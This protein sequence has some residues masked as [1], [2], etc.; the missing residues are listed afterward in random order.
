MYLNLLI[1]WI[2]Q[3]LLITLQWN[4]HGLNPE[5]KSYPI[6]IVSLT[7]N[8]EGEKLLLWLKNIRNSTLWSYYEQSRAV[9]VE[10]R[11]GNRALKFHVILFIT[12]FIT[13]NHPLNDRHIPHCGTD[14]VI[15]HPCCSDLALKTLE[16]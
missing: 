11:S 10:T 4:L 2:S 12:P 5:D 1:I 15:I 8:E 6:Q 9:I 3:D 7:S 14:R 13:T 16:V